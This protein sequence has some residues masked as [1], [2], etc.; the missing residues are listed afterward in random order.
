MVLRTFYVVRD[1]GEHSSLNDI[2]WE[3]TA[4]EFA[5]YVTAVG[6]NTFNK[7]VHTLHD[8]EE[9]AVADAEKRLYARDGRI[10]L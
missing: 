7:E 10:A 6:I 4:S 3:T 8:S 5:G 1:P 2:V 9:T